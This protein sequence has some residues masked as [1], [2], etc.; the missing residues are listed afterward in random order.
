LWR[1]DSR[2]N[3]VSGIVSGAYLEPSYPD[4]PAIFSSIGKREVLLPTGGACEYDSRT[5]AII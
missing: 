4:F 2:L 3:W 5:E 1:R